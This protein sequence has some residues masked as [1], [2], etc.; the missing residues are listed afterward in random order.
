MFLYPHSVLPLS[1]AGSGHNQLTPSQCHGHLG[2]FFIGVCKVLVP[3]GQG[4]GGGVTVLE[5]AGKGILAYKRF[6][7]KGFCVQG[8]RDVR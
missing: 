4:S 6:R 3:K 5:T 7:G 1:L 8:I 2:I